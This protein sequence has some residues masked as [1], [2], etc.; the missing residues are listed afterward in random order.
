MLSA[1]RRAV[2]ECEDLNIEFSGVFLEKHMPING[3]KQAD[4]DDDTKSR[5][6]VIYRAIYVL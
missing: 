4:D 5:D 3:E 2:A 1:K 6:I